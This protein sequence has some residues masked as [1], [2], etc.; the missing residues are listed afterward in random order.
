[1]TIMNSPHFQLCGKT[2]FLP[3]I[4]VVV[5]SRSLV[6]YPNLGITCGLRSP[7]VSVAFTAEWEMQDF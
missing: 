4:E 2:Y 5:Q 1:M 3:H 7:R 6:N